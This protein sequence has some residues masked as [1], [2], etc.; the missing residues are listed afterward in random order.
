M[1]SEKKATAI[2]SIAIL[3]W[4]SLALLSDFNREIPTFQLMAMSFFVGFIVI[5][6]KWQ[7]TGVNALVLFKQ[8]M[9]KW[10]LTLF[11]LFGYHFF[12]F[13]ALRFAPVLQASLVAYLCPLFIIILTTVLLK[14]KLKPVFYISVILSLTGCWLLIW[15]KGLALS[16]QYFWGYIFAFAA[17]LIWS[18]YSVLSS[19]LPKTEP[20]NSP[21][22]ESE[23]E[24]QASSDFIGWA[25]GIT[26]LLAAICHFF[27]EQTLWTLT[28][29]QWLGVVLLGAGPV[30]LAFVVWDIGVKHGNLPLLGTL[31]YLTPLIST[32][33][34]I[35]LTDTSLTYQIIIGG[36]LIIG[37]AIMAA[38]NS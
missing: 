11:G 23:K 12:Y 34:L 32:S 22:N 16:L 37:G 20:E 26:A 35:L 5:A 3:L 15:Q 33:L 18:L 6:I 25:C 31:S 7:C 24:Q 4:G 13:M 38:K 21:E 10:A 2:G 36:I 14:R 1:I 9:S 17:A 27:L 19:F 28:D 30:G 8:P 29:S